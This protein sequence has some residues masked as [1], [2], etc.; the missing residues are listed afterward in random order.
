MPKNPIP[1]KNIALL[2]F[3]IWGTIL[4]IALSCLT[5][6]EFFFWLGVI[7]GVFSGAPILFGTNTSIIGKIILCF[8]YYLV[9]LFVVFI[10]GW[11]SICWFC[12]SCH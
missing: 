8:G 7:V 11:V 9:S 1:W 6:Q 4:T 10:L 3:P 12:P 2:T 5:N